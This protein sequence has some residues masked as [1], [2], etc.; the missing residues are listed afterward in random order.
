MSRPTYKSS[1]LDVLVTDIGHYYCE[2]VIRPPSSR[3]T[4]QLH[5]HLI[6]ALYSTK[7]CSSEHVPRV[8][9]TL[10]VR[11]LPEDALIYF[12]NWV[13]HEPWTFINDGSDPSN[14]VE[15]FNFLT[16]GSLDKYC[17]T[18]TFKCT[19]LDGK[20]S[21]AKVKQLCRKKTGNSTRYEV[22]KT[23]VKS[24]SKRNVN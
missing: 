5:A 18:K 10:T 12:A 22:L 1:V 19:N 3:T 6:T 11:P 2:P 23:E 21:S 8:P 4:L 24:N 9:K 17:P 16:N 13:Q 14:M 7:T 15:R 20:I